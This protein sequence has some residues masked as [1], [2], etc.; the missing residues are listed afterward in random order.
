MNLRNI[1]SQK[2]LPL[3]SG[4]TCSRTAVGYNAFEID[5]EGFGN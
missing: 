1:S 3:L 2:H 5:S 4:W